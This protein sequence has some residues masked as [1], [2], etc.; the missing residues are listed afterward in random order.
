MIKNLII[1]ALSLSVI[2]LTGITCDQNTRIN[3]YDRYNKNCETLLDSIASWN[4]S[5][6]D[7]T[8]ET[9]TYCDYIESRKHLD[10]LIWRK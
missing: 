7:T 2:I 3:A 1:A 6:L 10:S 5:F 9:D 4:N 8:A